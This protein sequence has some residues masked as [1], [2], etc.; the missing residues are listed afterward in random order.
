M[1]NGLYV[2]APDITNY[3][4]TFTPD[5][6]TYE[7]DFPICVHYSTRIDLK[8]NKVFAVRERKQGVKGPGTD[9]CSKLEDRL[10]MQLGDGF[11]PA[12]DKID[13]IVP[14]MQIVIGVLKIF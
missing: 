10:E 2:S 4:A 3:D 14:L 6:I 11:D 12:R 13:H 9:A 8:L 7:N 5:G 1:I